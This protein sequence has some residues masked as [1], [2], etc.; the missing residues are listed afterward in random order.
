ML[1]FRISKI[2]GIACMSNSHDMEISLLNTELLVWFSDAKFLGHIPNYGLLVQFLGK[3]LNYRPLVVGMTKPNTFDHLNIGH[4]FRQC[5]ELQT[6]S[7]WHNLTK[8]I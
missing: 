1:H 7:S 6:I 5:L 3:V 2:E 8:H 4:V